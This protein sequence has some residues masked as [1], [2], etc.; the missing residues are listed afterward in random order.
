MEQIRL[1]PNAAIN[2]ESARHDVTP[3]RLRLRGIAKE[4]DQAL[5]TADRSSEHQSKETPI[6]FTAVPYQAW[7]NRSEG[8]MRIWIP[9]I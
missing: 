9:T 3:L 5:Y 6:S 7:G 4:L 1:D 2:E 8:A